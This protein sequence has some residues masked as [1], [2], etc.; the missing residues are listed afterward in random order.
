MRY[1]WLSGLLALLAGACTPL[2]ERPATA[3]VRIRWEHD[4]ENLDPLALPTQHANEAANL[5]YLGLLQVDFQT[6]QYA[7]ALAEALPRLQL[8]GDSLTQLEFRLRPT[9]TWDDGRPVLA[10]DVAFTLKLMLCPGLP[11]EAVRVQLDFIRDIQLDPADPHHFTLV[12]EGQAPEYV[13]VASDFPLLPEAALDP[14]H[15]LRSYSLA[16]LQTNPALASAPAVLALARRYRQ[17]DLAHHPERLPGCGP[18]QLVTWRPNSSLTFQRKPNW[19]ADRL[20]AAPPVLQ[21]RPRQLQFSILPDEGSAA[22]ALRRHEIDVYPQVSARSFQRLQ[23]SS[24][25]RQELA[26]YTSNSY[27]LVTVGFNTQLPLLHDK[28]TRQA[29]S[30]L[31]DPAALLAGTQLGQGRRTVGLLSPASPF[32]NDSLPLL[33]HSPSRA[34]ALLRRAGWQQT[35]TG[36]QRGPASATQPRQQLRLSVRY[37]ADE[38]SFATVALQLRTAAAAL[39]IPIELRPTEPALLTATLRA[40][41][42]EVYVRT[43]KGNP[44]GY[45][46]M[47]ILHSRGVGGSNFTRFSSPAT[48]RLLDAIAAV[49][50]VARKRQLLRR[51]QVVLQDEVPLVPLFFLPYRLV[52][53]RHLGHLLP[54][55]LRP[56]YASTTITWDGAPSTP[57][58]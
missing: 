2:T 31:L 38:S 5:L 9:A 21:A 25:A 57:A 20:P 32:Y 11:N 42:F 14:T 30:Y 1:S 16:A 48:D 7:P 19:W 43:L 6:Q 54:S 52:A 41:D 56:G 35:D 8:L 51:F 49:G 39:G 50:P 3:P 44:F 33:T 45:N 37:R 58:R 15:S 24:T 22:L 29:L 40:G 27:E 47:P 17:A 55:G 18:Y 36:W 28:L 10:T 26:F 4:P 34:A 13:W 46:F 53:D 12:C 23:A